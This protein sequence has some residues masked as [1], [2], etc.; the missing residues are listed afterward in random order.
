MRVAADALSKAGF[1][2]RSH[3]TWLEH[4]ESAFKILPEIVQLHVLDDG[5]IQTVS[6][7]QCNHAALAPN[8]TFEY[9]HAAGKTVADSLAKGFEQWVAM[10]FVTLLG[11]LQPKPKSCTTLAWA[12]SSLGRM[13]RAVLGPVAHFR[14]QPLQKTG[15]AE[16][17]E[18]EFCPCCLLT[19]SYETF[20]ELVEGDRLCCLRLFAAREVDGTP[21]ADCRVNGEDWEPGMQALRNYV[22]SWPGRGYESRKQYVVVHTI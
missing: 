3:K 4:R 22:N 16:V 13:R 7:V 9:Q 12:N 8:G 21:Q 2:V 18:H 1:A 15:R 11:A 19:K 6:T 17:D 20:R 10:D 5:S 14:Q